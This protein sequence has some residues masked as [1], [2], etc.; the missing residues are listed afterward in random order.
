MC[1]SVAAAERACTLLEG[2]TGTGWLEG[3]SWSISQEMCAQYLYGGS[4][5]CVCKC[6]RCR[7]TSVREANLTGPALCFG[8][9]VGSRELQRLRR[10]GKELLDEDRQEVGLLPTWGR[11]GVVC[12]EVLRLR[13]ARSLQPLE[14]QRLQRRQALREGLALRID[15][16]ASHL[17][18]N[19]VDANDG[20]ELCGEDD[21]CLQFYTSS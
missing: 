3:G 17:Q 14:Q 5:P 8:V 1:P 16:L 13:G 21:Q 18:A 6:F 20:Y 19:S 12:I 4:G 9:R 10:S 7:G 2:T 11:R 15:Q